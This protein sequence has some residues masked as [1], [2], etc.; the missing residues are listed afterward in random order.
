MFLFFFGNVIFLLRCAG[1]EDTPKKAPLGVVL[2]EHQTNEVKNTNVPDSLPP[3]QIKNLKINTNNVEKNNTALVQ[4]D[5]IITN[6]TIKNDSTTVLEKKPS[7]SKNTTD[8]SHIIPNDDDN[9]MQSGALL[10]GF[11]VVVGLSV[12]LLICFVV[13]SA[14]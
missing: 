5:Q 6:Q 7:T 11:L 13:K 2:G 9:M 10:R 14:R 1:G 12:L 4:H 3:P 8:L